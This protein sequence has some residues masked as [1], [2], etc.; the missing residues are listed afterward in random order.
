M[1]STVVF[2]HTART[3][4][5]SIFD[6]EVKL[7]IKTVPN[8]LSYYQRTK[9]NHADNIVVEVSSDINTVS[10]GCSFCRTEKQS[11]PEVV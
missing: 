7:F 2:R 1:C 5:E 10:N 3:F 9:T 8:K 11:E 4:I 6:F